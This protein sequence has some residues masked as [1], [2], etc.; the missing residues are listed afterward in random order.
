MPGGE[1]VTGPLPADPKD[2]TLALVAEESLR[3]GRARGLEFEALR[4]P[5]TSRVHLKP[6]LLSRVVC[7]RVASPLE[8]V[9][10]DEPVWPICATCWRIVTGAAP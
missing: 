7:G 8:R 3:E 1:R 2:G 6:L 5:K 4:H 10:E 9:D